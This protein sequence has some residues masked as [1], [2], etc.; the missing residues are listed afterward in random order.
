[1]KW[2][3]ICIETD[4]YAEEIISELMIS[5]GAAG[6]FIEG[7][8][9]P[10]GDMPGD[11]LDESLA[12]GRPFSVSAYFPCNGEQEGMK[13]RIASKVERVKELGLD[14]PLGSLTVSSEEMDEADWEN[15]WKAYFKPEKISDILVVK[16]SWEEYKPSEGEIVVEIDPGM[17]FGTGTH[18]TTQM[19]ANL[20]EEY[21][22]P[23]MA[24]IDVGCGSGIL[25]IVSAKL[26][27]GVVYALDFD[28]VAVES[29]SKNIALN[30]CE[31][32]SVVKSDLLQAL[33]ADVRADIIVAN[34]I[35]DVIIRL[36]PDAVQHIKR[37]GM[38]ICSGIIE[39]R[40]VEVEEALKA[41][42]FRLISIP[43][44]GEWRAIACKYKG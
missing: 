6:V 2:L 17:A 4:P 38:F 9:L 7:G 24:V 41:A 13:V 14:V 31:S 32:A 10:K 36:I 26:G 23:G 11:Y 19:C 21:L 8:P 27:A 30:K 5:S 35:A 3:K 42:G 25:S 20:L 12:D 34:I 22:E 16:P 28:D 39:S 1:M 44:D 37:N 18:E 15:A 29:A 33:E 43:E 40:L